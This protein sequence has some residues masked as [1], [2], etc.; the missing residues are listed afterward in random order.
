MGGSGVESITLVSNSLRDTIDK[1]E[2]KKAFGKALAE[3][4]YINVK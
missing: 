4:G 1:L 3:K 2:V